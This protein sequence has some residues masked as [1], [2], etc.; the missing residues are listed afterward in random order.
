MN[1]LIAKKAAAVLMAA[2]LITGFVIIGNVEKA[3]LEK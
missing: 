3:R 2:L 1:T